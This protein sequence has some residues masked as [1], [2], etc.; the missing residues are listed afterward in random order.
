MEAPRKFIKAA[1]ITEGTVYLNCEHIVSI[2][3]YRNRTENQPCS[4]I[5]YIMD[6]GRVYRDEFDSNDEYD[7]FVDCVLDD[8]YGHVT[9][10]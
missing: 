5:T 8:L 6:N 10:G 1:S 2:E 9:G 3:C 7:E 4:R